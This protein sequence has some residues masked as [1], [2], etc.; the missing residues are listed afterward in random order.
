MPSASFNANSMQPFGSWQFTNMVLK[1]SGQTMTTPA[2]L[3]ALF[4]PPAF[5]N[6]K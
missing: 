6:Q 4:S 3:G 5:E 2:V 1:V